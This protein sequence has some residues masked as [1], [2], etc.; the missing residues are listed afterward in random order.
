[1]AQEPDLNNALYGISPSGSETMVLDGDNGRAWVKGDFLYLQTTLAVFS[2]RVLA[3]S[4]G[5][6]K[7]RAYKLPKTTRY[8][9]TNESGRTVSVRVMR[10]PAVAAEHGSFGNE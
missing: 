8:T 4:H 2:P 6:G 1:M 7:Y 9:G 5:N 10:S 3:T